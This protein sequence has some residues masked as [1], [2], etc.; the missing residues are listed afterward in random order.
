MDI[1]QFIFDTYKDTYVNC[2]KFKEMVKKNF[3]LDK[4]VISDLYVRITNYQVNKYGGMVEK[5]D[6]NFISSKE[7]Q[8]KIRTS[9][10][11]ARNIRENDYYGYKKVGIKHDKNK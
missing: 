11:A 4:N 5:S 1:E 2:K 6:F 10:R 8:E 9:R 7:E 3:G